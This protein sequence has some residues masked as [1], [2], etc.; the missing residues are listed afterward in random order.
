MLNG[1]P[2]T[3]TIISIFNKSDM[4]LPHIGTKNFKYARRQNKLFHHWSH[5][6]IDTWIPKK[7]LDPHHT[8]THQ[9]FKLHI[10]ETVIF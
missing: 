5:P 3:K 6:L 10:P 9:R 2:E 1:I 4:G 8:A 7:Y